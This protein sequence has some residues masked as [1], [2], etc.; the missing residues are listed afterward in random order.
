M[1]IQFHLD[2]DQYI[3]SSLKTAV[4]AG[5]RKAA[6]L[7]KNISFRGLAPNTWKAICTR[8]GCFPKSKKLRYDWNQEFADILLEPLAIPWGKVLNE[9][10]LE[11]Y[12]TFSITV[13]GSLRE[14]ARD[15]E[16]S[17]APICGPS[18]RPLKGILSQI[19]L[20]EKQVQ[21]KIAE[22]QRLGKEAARNFPSSVKRLVLNR[23]RPVYI[24]C[25]EESGT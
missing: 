15:L 6:Q 13:T 19:L 20:L 8:K 25:K 11:L 12:G 18:Y 3:G 4:C 7:C 5:P 10:L 9:Q 1:M 14:F 23:M 22:S 2:I 24:K 17:V 16:E 21:S